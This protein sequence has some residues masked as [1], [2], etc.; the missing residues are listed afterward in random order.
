MYDAFQ[1]V[2]FLRWGV[3]ATL[4]LGIVGAC[5]PEYYKADA[6]EEVYNI[7]DNKWKSGYGEKANYTIS[8]VPA[9]PNDIHVA[10]AVPESGVLSLSEAVA[11]ATAHNRGYQRQ[12][13]QL[14]LTALDLTLAR[15]QFARQWFGTIDA[16]YITDNKEEQVGYNVSPGFT[17]LLA[18]GASISANIALDWSR[19]LTDDPRTSLRSLLSAQVV[20]PLLRGSGRLV[21]QENL[22]Q[23]E[24]NA[25]YQIR[26]FNRFRKNFVISVVD[27]YYRV[28]Q[29]KDQVTNAENNYNSRIESRERL[30]MEAE[31]GRKPHF[32]VDQAR[33]AELTARDAL[34]RA[35]QSYEQQLDE[36]KIFLAL[37]T[38]AE[39]SLDP[40]ELEVLRE[41]GVT[42]PAYALDEAVST[43][44]ARRLD[45]A[46]GRDAVDDAT[47]KVA[48]AAD[49]LGA[50]LDLI[51]SAD[52]SSTG[53]NDYR[54]LEFH[55]GRYSLGVEADL[56][57]DRKAERNAYREALI[58][59]TQREREFQNSIDQVKLEVR[60]AYRRLREEAESYRTQELS[61]ELARKRVESTTILLKAGRATTR[62][63]LESQDALL[64]A[65]NSLTAAL[66]GHAIAKLGFFADI[67][68]LHVRPD[69]MWE[70]PQA[71]YASGSEAAPAESRSIPE[72]ATAKHQLDFRAFLAESPRIWEQ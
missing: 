1:P 3:C 69:G 32:E 70:Q 46:N 26:T 24:R 33:Q 14:Y 31:A 12:K 6:D 2:R 17:Q 49:G 68:L 35:Q 27:S 34:V 52:V 47:R 51:G 59:L 67:G 22:T 63:L 54:R 21:V 39:L 37:P 13:E 19:F 29:Q 42:E 62:D 56:P 57:L 43:A 30:E 8:D 50:D 28:L 10:K 65:Q 71:Q 15:H 9:S 4:F 7:I 61:L 11:V 5:S 36:F 72:D 45:L 66:I 23:A 58:T 18:G 41:S 16:A 38:D 60:Q 48:V 25:L 20:Q 44:L 53:R 40:N 64:A 55:R